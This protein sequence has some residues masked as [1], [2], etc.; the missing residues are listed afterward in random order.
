VGGGSSEVVVGQ[1]SQLLF[2]TSLQL[3]AVRL[4]ERTQ[5]HDPW[6]T[7]DLARARALL[8]PALLTLPQEETCPLV[9]SGGTAAY[10]GAMERSEAGLSVAPSDLHG[11]TLTQDQLSRRIALLAALPLAQRQRVPG[12]DPAR[13]DVIVAGALL[14]EGLLQTLGG[15]ELT[16]SVS[17]L[18]YGL[19]YDLLAS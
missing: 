6:T 1:G 16:L 19:L 15:S 4:T 2:F 11:L 17:G 3:G 18:R 5:P 12:L 8:A 10:L 14:Q 13:A 7:E 9:A